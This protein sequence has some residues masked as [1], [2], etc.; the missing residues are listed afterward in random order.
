MISLM[1][2]H[3][4]TYNVYGFPAKTKSNLLVVHFS[5]ETYAFGLPPK[6]TY[7]L[8]ETF[9]IAAKTA[10]DIVPEEIAVFFSTEGRKCPTVVFTKV[11]V[12]IHA[13]LP[14]SMDMF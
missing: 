5:I 1:L 12:C 2:I 3:H 9:S 11:F 10:W 4:T 8:P 13:D 6:G 14:K 7:K